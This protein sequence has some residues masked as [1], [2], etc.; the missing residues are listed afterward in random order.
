M[1]GAHPNGRFASVAAIA[2]LLCCNLVTTPPA[3]AD[4]A[5]DL[6][7]IIELNDNYAEASKQWRAGEITRAEMQARQK[8]VQQEARQIH[9]SY[10]RVGSPERRDWDS[11]VQAAKKAHSRELRQAAQAA[12]A[13]RRAEERAIA[14]E[15]AAEQRAIAEAAAAERAAEER[16]EALTRPI[17]PI[18]L[19]AEI[20]P[21]NSLQSDALTLAPLVQEAR[22][23]GNEAFRLNSKSGRTLADDARL[24]LIAERKAIIEPQIESIRSE[25]SNENDDLKNLNLMARALGGDYVGIKKEEIDGWPSALVTAVRNNTD[26]GRAEFQASLKRSSDAYEA[27]QRAA[28]RDPIFNEDNGT[29]ALI[30]AILIGVAMSFGAPRGIAGLSADG[31]TLSLAGWKYQ[32]NS[33]SGVVL[34]S[35][36]RTEE[37]T[38]IEASGGHGVMVGGTGY[39]T[40]RQEAVKDTTT[41]D[42]L[43]IRDDEGREH[44]V[45][46]EDFGLRLRIGNRITVVQATGAR[47]SERPV[48]LYNENTRKHFYSTRVMRDLLKPSFLWALVHAG[49]VALIMGGLSFP[50]LDR[51]EVLGSVLATAFCLYWIGGNRLTVG[52]IRAGLFDMGAASKALVR[53]VSGEAGGQPTSAA[54]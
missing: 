15:A 1:Q 24:S 35:Q 52:A 32:L 37:E 41:F 31:R 39:I 3:R 54:V 48:L 14:Q 12:A 17:V 7:R 23:I 47:G 26:W 30:A 46:L 4:E 38:V 18:R 29:Y 36:Q 27:V 25:Y 2:I 42:H 53:Q 34:D 10:G 43:F 20:K 8:A 22:L 19:S 49:L 50:L 16:E 28:N 33:L 5:S 9:S 6:A 13:E 40:P 51:G 11:K 45:E 21:E 44:E